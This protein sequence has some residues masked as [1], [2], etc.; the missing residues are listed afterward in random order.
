[1]LKNHTLLF[2]ALISF[3]LP[4]AQ[5][6]F[7]QD[8]SY[9]VQQFNKLYTSDSIF[10]DF[11]YLTRTLSPSKNRKSPETESFIIYNAIKYLY[12]KGDF[13]LALKQIDS[14]K[15]NE[16]SLFYPKIINLKGVIL[17]LQKENYKAVNAFLKA[18]ELYK[19]SGRRIAEYSVYN[20]IANIYLSLGDYAQAYKYSRKCFEELEKYPEN[21]NYYTTLGVLTICEI[22]TGRLSE[23]REHLKLLAPA[24]KGN[25]PLAKV[26]TFYAFSEYSNAKGRY[27]KGIEEAQICIALSDKY[28]LTQYVQLG[29]ILLMKSH[30]AL[31]QFDRA[32]KHGKKAESLTQSTQNL[33]TINSIS[34]G[35]ATAYAG[36]GE[37]ERA[38]FYQHLS[39]SI[40]S[41]ERAKENRSRLD[42]LLLQ[43]ETVA[44]KNEI[45][46]QDAEIAQQKEKITKRNSQIQLIIAISIVVALIAILIIIFYRMRLSRQKDQYEKQMLFALKVGEENERKRISEELH[47]AVASELTALKMTLEQSSLSNKNKT[48]N[49]LKKAHQTVRR[50]SH[51][52]SP[53][54]LKEKGLSHALGFFVDSLELSI[55]INF[56]TN[57][58]DKLNI[59]RE[60]ALVLF[61]CS[62]EVIQN[63]LKHS[64]ANNIDVQLLKTRDRLTISIEDDGKGF[65]QHTEKSQHG[66][67]SIR[68]RIH[69][70]GGEF[71]LESQQDKGTS[72]FI[73]IPF[74]L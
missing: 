34:S 11:D 30:N 8:S 16:K 3:S 4:K 19:K 37:Y 63:A 2:I 71:I 46:R 13:Q 26:L 35:L 44:A 24:K 51:N 41:R 31:D 32:I 21:T 36:K 53:V 56:H 23:A 33:S 58:N 52:L 42:S 66:I 6:S 67:A 62:Q 28:N 27:E 25:N 29:H 61:R 48:L 1:M 17:S 15:L 7:Q 69:S 10:R 64:K 65:N 5:T 59:S 54:H 68:E 72:V 57:V 22:N 73:S 43:F 45:L 20:N 40:R 14:L 38:F 70:I 18:A 50:I 39:D 49:L 60:T 9:I 74:K 55:D 47:D 12:A